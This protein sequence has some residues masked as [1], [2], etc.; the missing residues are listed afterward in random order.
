M[1]DYRFDC[2]RCG[3]SLE[4]PEEMLGET[5]DCPSCNGQIQIPAPAQPEKPRGMA[6]ASRSRRAPQA[7][8]PPKSERNLTPVIISVVVL[9]A[10]VG[11]AAAFFMILRDPHRVE[12]P[13]SF[14]KWDD[15]DLHKAVEKLSEKERKLFVAYAARV[16]LATAL[17]GEGVIPEVK[18]VGDVLEDQRK[19]QKEQEQQELRRVPLAA[20]LLKEQADAKRVM[21]NA[22]TVSLLDITFQDS[23]STRGIY[24][25]YFAMQV[26]FENRTSK[27]IAGIKGTVLFKDIFG[28]LIQGI[29]LSDDGGVASNDAVARNFTMDYNQFKDADKKLRNTSRD[30]LTIEWEPDTYLFTDGS[31]MTM[32][33]GEY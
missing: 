29:R 30:K 26:G 22:V 9:L 24:S 13:S 3:Q 5:I 11:G 16:A 28:D 6:Q 32:A 18:T 17:G 31:K 14:E 12:V 27:D 8:S 21:S 33:K 10:L 2:P 23:D 25:D 20:K 19:W 15:E 4:A 7:S 1:S